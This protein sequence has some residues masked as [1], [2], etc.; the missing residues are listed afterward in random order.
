MDQKLS[1]AAYHQLIENAYP[2]FVI[3]L[4]QKC[5]TRCVKIESKPAEPFKLPSFEL[6]IGKRDGPPEAPPLTVG[7]R[8]TAKEEECIGNCAGSYV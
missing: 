8:L 3:T 4:N 5:F 7:S 6:P 1:K 2:T